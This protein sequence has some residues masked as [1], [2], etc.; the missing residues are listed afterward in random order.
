MDGYR[1]TQEPRH[2]V[3]RAG[4]WRDGEC[5]GGREAALLEAGMDNCLSK[6]V[7]LETLEQTLAYYS[8]RY[9]TAAAS[10]ESKQARRAPCLFGANL[11]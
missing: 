10:A 11:P 9:A 5:A 8:Q 6:P 7:T 4:D 2:A 1:L 3:Q